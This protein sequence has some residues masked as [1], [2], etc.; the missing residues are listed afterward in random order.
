[1]I[2]EYKLYNGEVTIGFDKA[3]HRF[4]GEDGKPMLSV[5]GATG[6]VDKSAPLMGW[7]AKSMALYLLA[8]RDKGNRII[9]EALVGRAKRE[10]RQISKEAANLGTEIHEWVSDWILKK[11]PEMPMNEKVVN[12]IT[13]FLKFQK[14]NKFKWIDSERLVYS[15]KYKYA[16][17]LDA[18]ATE[19]D[20]FVLVDFKSGN[21][22]Y[23]DMRFQ[24]A[25]YRLAYEEETGKKF[26][27]NLLIRFGKET[28]E[29][30]P[31]I[32]DDYA[33]DKKAFLNCLALK[34]RLK[35][36]DKKK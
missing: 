22:L 12:G 1:M 9:T 8:E 2:T 27:K 16:G 3:R 30:Y 14:E 13:A 32:L 25:G 26:D 18:T 23:D 17:W 33:K 4:Y 35:E 19:E 15:R 10:Y 21:G 24:V 5:T 11:N 29:F 28:G 36:L 7:V 20:S 31:H 34:N 6:V